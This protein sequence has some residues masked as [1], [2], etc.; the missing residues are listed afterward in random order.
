M[1]TVEGLLRKQL[2]NA[3]QRALEAQAELDELRVEV[4]ALR[5]ENA[6]LRH[7]MEFYASRKNYWRPWG[8]ASQVSQPAIMRDKGIKAREVL[9]K[10]YPSDKD[11]KPWTGK[12]NNVT[13]GARREKGV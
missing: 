6:R 5:S 12:G 10:L 8:K 9:G 2:A 4:L 13:S 3:T 7:A 1:S 11:G